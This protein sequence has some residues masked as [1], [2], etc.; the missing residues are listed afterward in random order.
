MKLS[1][2]TI[3]DV[4]DSLL[5][6]QVDAE[7]LEPSDY[8]SPRDPKEHV[9]LGRMKERLSRA[10]FSADVG[11]APE[12]RHELARRAIKL[13]NDRRFARQQIVSAVNDT[14]S[15]GNTAS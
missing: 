5:L 12:L 3:R 15:S 2:Q 1:T 9:S 11:V 13:N 14:L 7:I 4:F 10:G 6:E 8:V